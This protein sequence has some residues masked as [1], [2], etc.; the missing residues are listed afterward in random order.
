MEQI[1][2]FIEEGEKN[3]SKIFPLQY[4]ATENYPGDS[5]DGELNFT[6]WT[7]EATNIAKFRADL[8]KQFIS[9]RQTQLI[10]K[11]IEMVERENKK[12][13]VN[14]LQDDEVFQDKGMDGVKGFNQALST[15]TSKL[16]EL[17]KE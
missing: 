11:I 6:R 7:E 12:V 8:I 5:R 2:Q 10:Q 13:I 17:I 16:S 1:K 14:M 4:W 3:F 9:S 15:I